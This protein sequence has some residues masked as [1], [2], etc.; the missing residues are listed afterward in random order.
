MSAIANSL[1]A[2]TASHP[3][4]RPGD[5]PEEASG[6][7]IRPGD[8]TRLADVLDLTVTQVALD[9]PRVKPLLDELAVEYS[10]RY[11]DFFSPAGAQE[12]L[13][14]YPA[15]EFESPQGALLVLQHGEETVAG[16][17]FRRY[18]QQTAEFKRIWTHSAH[19]RKG[20]ARRVLA[21]LEQVARERGYTRVYLTTGPR[22]P[23]A[24][25]LYLAAGYTPLFDLDADPEEI[26]HLA[27]T[28]PLSP[29]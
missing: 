29:A 10:T 8:A 13:T 23:E 7:G 26:R 17:A 21:E 28:K 3:P 12:E 15:S 22:Q 5:R 25:A 2:P 14:R 4:A 27:F 16:G 20:L 6:T 18:D 24:K 19:R 9:D 11:G 1:T